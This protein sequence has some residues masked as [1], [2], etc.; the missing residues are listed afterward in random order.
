MSESDYDALPEEVKAMLPSEEER[1]VLDKVKELLGNKHNTI[2]PSLMEG[3]SPT[4]ELTWT[5]GHPSDY[6][7]FDDLKKK[8][9]FEPTGNI[10]TVKHYPDFEAS[11][12]KGEIDKL[13]V[14]IFI[15]NEK[16][17]K[18]NGLIPFAFERA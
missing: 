10:I 9:N 17:F 18:E 1:L 15:P 6:R 3:W 13:R 5:E 16:D 4:F 12:Y 11:E 7:K 8:Y 14:H 2:R